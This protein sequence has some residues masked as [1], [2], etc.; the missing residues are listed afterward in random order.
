MAAV[1]GLIAWQ[2]A[3]AVGEAHANHEVS[4]ALSIPRAWMYAF[5]SITSAIAAVSALFVAAPEHHAHTEEFE[6]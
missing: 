2:Y 5:M 4:Q 6:S 1:L 3:V